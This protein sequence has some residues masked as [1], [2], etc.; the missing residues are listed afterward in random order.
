MTA[1]Q[2]LFLALGL[3][4]GTACQDAHSTDVQEKNPINSTSTREFYQLLTYT[5]D[6][7]AQV[8][9]TDT[10]LEQAYLPSLKRMGITNIGVFKAIPSEKDSSLKTYVLIPMKSLD[11]LVEIDEHLAQDGDYQTA[12]RAYLQTPHDQPA[13]RRITSTVMRAFS[14]MPNMEPTKLTGDRSTRI[15]ELRSY[16]SSSKTYYKTKV[17]MFN[18]GGEITLFDRLEFNAIFYAEVLSGANMPNLMYMTTFSDMDSRDAHW[19][20]FFSSPEWTALKAMEKYKNS[21]S[22]ADIFFLSPTSYSDY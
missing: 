17:D 13:Y 12:G 4:I 19:K 18:A 11:Q 8:E 16:E 6:T 3:L 7:E 10:Y 21:V 5:F 14:D 22:R 9:M 2:Y 20:A 1:Y 15:Y